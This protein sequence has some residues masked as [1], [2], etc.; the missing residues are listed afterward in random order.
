LPAYFTISGLCHR[1]LLSP[2]AVDGRLE[3][4]FDPG[5]SQALCCRAAQTRRTRYDEI[6]TGP[7]EEA[8]LRLETLSADE[9]D[10]IASQIIETLDDEKAG[11]D[12]FQTIPSSLR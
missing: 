6:M 8:L 9:Q 3:R 4:V 10:E 7:L 5:V 2:N 1:A 11:A 12:R